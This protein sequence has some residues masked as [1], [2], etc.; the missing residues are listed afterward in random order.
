ML[1]VLAAMLLAHPGDAL[2]ATVDGYPYVASGYQA[3]GWQGY[4][5]NSNLGKIT[6]DYSPTQ[7]VRIELNK[8]TL[9]LRCRLFSPALVMK[10]GHRYEISFKAQGLNPNRMMTFTPYL[11]TEVVKSLL[12]T[13]GVA[14]KIL[15]TGDEV[16]TTA[17]AVQSVSFTYTPS[18]QREVYFMLDVTTDRSVARTM[19][20]SDFTVTETQLIQ[21][22][23]GVENLVAEC[24]KGGPMDVTLKW[25][26]PTK[27][28]NDDDIAISAIKI[29]RN[30][31]PLATLTDPQYLV[32]GAECSYIDTPQMAGVYAYDISVVGESGLESDK[33]SITTPYI[34]K[35][36]AF[37][38]PVNFDFSDETI[39][40]FWELTTA[41][42][43]NG[44]VFN[45]TAN[46][47][48]ISCTRDGYKPTASTLTT[49]RFLLDAEKA[50]KISYDAQITN[51]SNEFGYRL[52]LDGN[53]P[54]TPWEMTLVETE[55]YS[56][57]AN[58]KYFPVEEIFS[59]LKS[60]EASFSFIAD[61]AKFTSSYY[62]TTLYIANLKV[63]EIA[64]LPKAATSLAAVADSEGKREVRLSWVN[65]LVSET[66]LP[67]ASIKAT[68]YRD[69]QV[70]ETLDV[71]PGSTSAFTDQEAKGLSDGYHTYMVVIDNVSG[72][73][74]LEEPLS[75]KTGYVGSPVELPYIADFDG[76]KLLFDAI[77]TDPAKTDGKIFEIRDGK[78]VL[79]TT[80]AGTSDALV[81]PP[82]SLEKGKIYEIAVATAMTGYSTLG[83]DLLLTS[84]GLPGETSKTVISSTFGKEVKV[85]FS[86]DETGVFFPVITVRAASYGSTE[87]EY[88]V[89]AL[90]IIEDATL[91]TLPF[92]ADFT[93]EEGRALWKLVDESTSGNKTFAFNE[94]NEL[95]LR[96]GYSSTSTG[97]TMNDW[98]IFP[99]VTIESGVTYAIEFEGKCSATS[100]Y[101][102]TPYEIWVGDGD[103]PAYLTSGTK[104]TPQEE[105][106]LTGEHAV[107]THS[108]DINGRVEP[109][110]P[111]T[112]E[113]PGQPA[114]ANRREE[115]TDPA[116]ANK[117]IGLRFGLGKY[118]NQEVS[119][120]SIKLTSDKQISG[121]GE[122][123]GDLDGKAVIIG[124]RVAVSS[125][126]VVSVYDICGKS[127][128]T[129][130]G[131]TDLS[132]LAPGLYL[133]SVT[134]G[135]NSFNTKY[136]K[137]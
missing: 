113:T 4:L 29:W 59:P 42:N 43:A 47:A 136:L 39:N 3:E 105:V 36:A 25:H 84:D 127:M 67:L 99:P 92:T 1:V 51:K 34:G 93:S 21:K 103:S 90:S 76:D 27:Y 108:F 45:P 126:A 112:P 10:P 87:Y 106:K 82:V 50:Y 22:P 128:I 111:E 35:I 72:H 57:S 117:F 124:D 69:S 123:C 9:A 28:L 81:A 107:H 120:K 8:S 115:S 83:F 26:N 7:P 86:M 73:T 135:Q 66:G 75:V 63:E 55:A 114:V 49:P 18:E 109:A 121:I 32:A 77:E 116:P 137:K 33:S 20:F 48:S 61:M 118:A 94:D 5:N 68:V 132:I 79:K 46:P 110:A 133:I 80:A 89:T 74:L 41:E 122:T 30:G 44:W 60:G 104:V 19:A 65:P 54:D 62:S 130:K 13:D 71:E 96:E 11:T 95:T 102:M 53:D 129:S 134:D 125:S 15:H 17:A 91:A 119:I 70:L 14:E 85:R 40:G 101:Y 97:S 78:A 6:L 88:S 131:D 56:P 37:T 38:P 12:T 98:I 64:V 100:D 2:A 31:Q 52:T 58:S 16:N 24:E 23:L